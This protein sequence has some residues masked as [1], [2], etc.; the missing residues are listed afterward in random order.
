MED[1][2]ASNER[3]S[4][5]VHLEDLCQV[6]KCCNVATCNTGNA[7]RG[8]DLG[9]LIKIQKNEAKNERGKFRR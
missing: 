7:D 3:L 2:R 9:H 1:G 4:S 8:A 6:A 5:A